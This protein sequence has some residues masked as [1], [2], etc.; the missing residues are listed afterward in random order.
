MARL[1]FKND[2]PARERAFLTQI[3][4]E[5]NLVLRWDEY[6]EQDVN[7]ATVRFPNAVEGDAPPTSTPENG[8]PVP[9]AEGDDGQWEDV[10]EEDEEDEESWAAVDRVLRKY[11]KAPVE[12][13]DAEGPFDERHERSV[14]EKMDEW[15]RQYYKVPIK[16]N[17]FTPC[18]TN[19]RSRRS[20]GFRS[21]TQRI[22]GN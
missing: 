22:L 8:T 15:K 4:Q 21:T 12:D 2:F 5:L 9:A 16:L 6:D 11:R 19:N 13:P 20:S 14:K 10:D 3:A 7:L 18:Y 1:A 17:F